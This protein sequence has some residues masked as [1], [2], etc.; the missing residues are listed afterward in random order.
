MRAGLLLKYFSA[1]Y[2][3][4]ADGLMKYWPFL[5]ITHIAAAS[6]KCWLK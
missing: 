4:D 2:I 5:N 3:H 1:E 6:L